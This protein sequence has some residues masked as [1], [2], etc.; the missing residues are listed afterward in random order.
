VAGAFVPG[1]GVDDRAERRVGLVGGLVG[2]E[3]GIGDSL[4]AVGF[5]FRRTDRVAAGGLAQ[6]ERDR[7]GRDEA[8]GV[9]DVDFL[10]LGERR[11]NEKRDDP[12]CF[13]HAV[14]LVRVGGGRGG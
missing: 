2:G 4:R 3:V 8:G 11:E 6:R 5:L 14:G 12:E 9:G 7:E 13:F 1:E 10:R